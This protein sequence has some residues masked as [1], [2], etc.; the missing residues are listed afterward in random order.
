MTEIFIRTAGNKDV[1]AITQLFYN[2]INN[3]NCRDYNES[4]V[5]AWSEGFK[6]TEG[7]LNKIKEQCFFLA[8]E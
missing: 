5:A 8:Q 2:T 3:I 7:W 1:G 6:N 4:Q